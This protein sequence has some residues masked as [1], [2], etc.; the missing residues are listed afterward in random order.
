LRNVMDETSDGFAAGILSQPP[1]GRVALVWRGDSTAAPPRPSATRFHLI[2]AGLNDVGLVLFSEEAEEVVRAR[3]LAVDGVL[4]WVDPL[5]S[6]KDRSRLDSLLREVAA[7]GIWVSAHPDVILK[8]GVKEVLYR[9][10][11]LGWSADTD[12][13]Q[14]VDDFS[15]RF[16]ARLAT[17]GARVIKQNR[18]NGGQGIWKVELIS[19]VGPHP[20]PS[21]PVRVLHALRGSVPEDLSL[22]AFMH[23]CRPYFSG[24][25]RIIDQAFQPRLPEGMVRCYL[26]RNEVV[27]YGHQLIKA[28]V[29]PQPGEGPDAVQPGPRIMHPADAPPFQNLRKELETEWVPAMQ[30]LLDIPTKWLP[31][32]WD[33]DFLYGPEAADGCDSY[34]LCEINVSSVAPYPDSAAAKVA[35]ATLAGICAAIAERRN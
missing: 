6:G 13:Y 22:G 29:A 12:L 16:P 9:T 28:L 5:S 2:F 32:L 19:D 27:G 35:E 31:A 7:R 10:R 3:L 17:G 20:E 1:I 8:M 25:G 14:S 15:R 4:V 23:R 30:T 11:K 18:G 24:D 33:A 26:S 21:A 34:V